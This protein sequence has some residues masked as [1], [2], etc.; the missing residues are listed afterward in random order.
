MKSKAGKYII[1]LLLAIAV[2]G[3]VY[4]KA[5]QRPAVEQRATV[6]PSNAAQSESGERNAVR[7][8]PLAT[9]TPVPGANATPPGRVTPPGVASLPSAA[10]PAKS[11]SA[12]TPSKPTKAKPAIKA[13]FIELGA[14]KCIPCK[15]MQPIMD[16]LRREYP[17]TLK[18]VFYDV[19]KDP[20]P[21]DKYGI[22]AI[23]TQVLLDGDDNEIFRHVGLWPK[24]EI[25]TTFKE[26]GIEL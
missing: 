8:S 16:E 4:I 5:Q 6:T 3:V 25:V 12:T 13:T 14:D 1:I 24:E 17:E 19:W 10:A 15:M 22:R 20:A 26:L 21:A 2:A 7:T 11:N 18:V 9:P 23:P